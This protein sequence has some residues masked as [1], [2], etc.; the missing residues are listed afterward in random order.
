MSTTISNASASTRPLK[1]NLESLR[2]L[3]RAHLQAISYENLDVQLG[4]P[5]TIE[6]PGDL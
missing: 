6:I 4:R 3:H 5:V 1:P 2:A